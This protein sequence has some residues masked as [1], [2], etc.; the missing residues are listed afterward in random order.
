MNFMHIIGLLLFIKSTLAVSEA[1]TKL[2]LVQS[3]KF[4]KT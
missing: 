3:V 4:E 1:D 2:V